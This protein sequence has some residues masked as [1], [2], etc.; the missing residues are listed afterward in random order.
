M[1]QWV[2]II[3]VVIPM[4]TIAGSAVAFVW[5]AFQ[6][7][8]EKRRDHFFHLMT[9]IDTDGKIATK[10]AAVYELRRFPEHREFIISFCRDLREQIDG[11]SAESLKREMDRTR[12]YFE[13]R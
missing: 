6:D 8:R 10:V 4:M 3:G 11:A 13:N 2:T 1:E 12:E 5:K 7:A 9:L